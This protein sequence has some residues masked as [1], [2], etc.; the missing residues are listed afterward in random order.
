MKIS[1]TALHLTR[2]DP[3]WVFSVASK[4]SGRSLYEKQMVKSSVYGS[5][6]DPSAEVGFPRI[7]GKSTEDIP[8]SDDI[9][10]IGAQN[11]LLV[12]ECVRV[13]NETI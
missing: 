3:V 7:P 13:A 8:Y 4:D 5:M 2:E 11:R 10:T 9:S 6:K 1:D 12:T